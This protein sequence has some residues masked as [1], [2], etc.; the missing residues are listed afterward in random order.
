MPGTRRVS[1]SSI[2]AADCGSAEWNDVTTN[3]Q[4]CRGCS[5]NAPAQTSCSP[6]VTW[7]SGPVRLSGSPSR[8]SPRTAL[9]T[10]NSASSET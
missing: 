5:A 10:A 6:G 7:P 2:P 3:C 9:Q 1:Q 8:S 4:P